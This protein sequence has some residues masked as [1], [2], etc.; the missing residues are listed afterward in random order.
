[1]ENVANIAERVNRNLLPTLQKKSE[2]DGS[3]SSK[4]QN[5]QYIKGYDQTCPSCLIVK[6]LWLHNTSQ[7]PKSFRDQCNCDRAAELETNR[8][9]LK[10]LKER[11]KKLI[12]NLFPL[13][14]AIPEL[15][16]YK[17]S[18]FIQRR[19]TE[20]AYGR[21]AEYYENF[22]DKYNPKGIGLLFVGEYGNGKTRLVQTLLNYLRIGSSCIFI[23]YTNLFD[24][25]QAIYQKNSIENYEDIMKCLKYVDMLAIDDIGVG[26]WTKHKEKI[27]FEI[28][29]QRKKLKKP[30][31]F[32]MNPEGQMQLGGRIQSRIKEICSFV[33]NEGS[34]F[35]SEALQIK[36]E[37]IKSN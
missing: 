9:Y 16:E 19:G 5:P 25:I 36:L 4:N 2:N 8:L 23:E 29:E 12:S 26:D 17:F 10:D 31:L 1:M 28:I 37:G 20:Y 7:G 18:N 24:R 27:L 21:A 22:Q 34:E 13:Y 33:D 35:R 15:E 32:T 14:E 30:I 11:N 3:D 6:K